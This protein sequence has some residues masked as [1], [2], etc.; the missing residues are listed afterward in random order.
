MHKMT[1]TREPVCYVC[2]D[3]LSTPDLFVKNASLSDGSLVVWVSVGPQWV[4]GHEHDWKKKL[5]TQIAN[6]FA[7][8]ATHK[9]CFG[10]VLHVRPGV[11]LSIELVQSVRKIMR[12]DVPFLKAHF[13]GGVVILPSSALELIVLGALRLLPPIKPVQTLVLTEADA[14][15]QVTD[16]QCPKSTKKNACKLIADMQWPDASDCP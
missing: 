8:I 9:M 1:L 15:D 5:K 14:H 10:L 16:W 11:Q 13:K 2:K 6:I 4:G 12:D 7:H 3:G